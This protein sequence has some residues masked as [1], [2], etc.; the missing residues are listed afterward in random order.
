MV[1]LKQSPNFT[2]VQKRYGVK[3]ITHSV[4]T[5]TLNFEFGSF[6]SWAAVPPSQPRDDGGKQ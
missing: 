6:P 3:A 1:Q 4:E 2:M 5:L